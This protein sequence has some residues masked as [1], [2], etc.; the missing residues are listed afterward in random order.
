MEIRKVACV[1]AGLIG[2]GWAAVFASRGCE[3]ALQDVSEAILE[4]A[5]SAVSANLRFMEAG[6]LLTAGEADAALGRIRT[7]PDLS[8]A[9]REAEYVQESVPDRYEVK[10]PIFEE[11]DSAAPAD[12]ILA[13]SASGLVMTEIQKV[14]KRPGRCILAHPMLPTHLLPLV[15]IAGGA[16]TWPET[17]E[18]TRTFMRS[19]GKTPVV[20]KREVPGYIVNRLQAALLREA[21]DLVHSGVAAAEDV[22]TAFCMGIGLR[23][24]F[25]G[26]L[27]RI[28]LAGDGV[29]RFIANYSKSYAYR[30]ENMAT[31][32]SIP[33]AAAEA[34]IRGVYALPKVRT[35]SL[36]EIKAWRDQ[37]LVKVLRVIREEG[38]PE[39]GREGA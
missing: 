27:L 26:P 10:R 34:V 13:S 5:V 39:R 4:R 25:I 36:D 17:V 3:V 15:E 18:R 20:L 14:T 2:Q 19:L 1:G 29:E 8:E 16:E 11:M 32:T 38:S 37:A 12:A 22:D 33:P 6:G 21:I 9:V 7:T 23:D 24:P 35:M 30:W 28:H 31:W